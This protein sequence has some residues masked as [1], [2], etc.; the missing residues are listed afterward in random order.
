MKKATITVGQELLERNALLLPTVF[1]LFCGHA[2]EAIEASQ[3]ET[4]VDLTTLTTS[5]CLLSHLIASLKHHLAYSCKTRKFGT[6]LYRSN[7]D[8]LPTLAQA[9]WKIRKYNSST[10]IPFNNSEDT[11]S[12]SY[13][14]SVL[15]KL[16]QRVH[17]QVKDFVEKDKS[18]S[19]EHHDIDAGFHTGGGGRPGISPPQLE[20]PPPQNLKIVMS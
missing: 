11:Q 7:S 3:L 10:S 18:F 20:F 13:D 19:R 17:A 1:E 6:L 5:R 12:V 16:N 9:L 15:D 14:S 8:L 4:S 2:A